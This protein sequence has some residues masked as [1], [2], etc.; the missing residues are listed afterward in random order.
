MLDLVGDRKV[1]LLELKQA[2]ALGPVEQLVR[3]RGLTESV[4]LQSNSPAVVRAIADRHLHAQLWRSRAQL[5]A[6]TAP[7]W[8]GSGAEQVEVDPTSAPLIWPACSM[9]AYRSGRTPPT[10]ARE[11]ARLRGSA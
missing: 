5:A 1:L 10:R 6:D 4:I 8:P 2:A 9:P 7:V 11:V 3:S